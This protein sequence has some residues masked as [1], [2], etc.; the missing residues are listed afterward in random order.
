MVGYTF[1]YWTTVGRA[2]DQIDPVVN[3]TQFGGGRLAGPAAPAFDLW[4]TG[5]WAQ[6]LSLGFEYQF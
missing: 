3:P 5:F 4:T 6:G 2:A 1:L